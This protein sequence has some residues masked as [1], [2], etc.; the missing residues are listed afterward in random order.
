MRCSVSYQISSE[1]FDNKISS[2]Q[3]ER[4]KLMSAEDKINRKEFERKSRGARDTVN[5]DLISDVHEFVFNEC[6]EILSLN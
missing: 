1:G 6:A 4:M 2:L 5:C 3:T